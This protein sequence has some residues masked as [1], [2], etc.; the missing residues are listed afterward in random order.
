MYSDKNDIKNEPI[1]VKN[2]PRLSKLSKHKSIK[3]EPLISK[4]KRN[5]S[6]IDKIFEISES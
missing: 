1:D 6:V 5:D 2:S 4:M 3:I